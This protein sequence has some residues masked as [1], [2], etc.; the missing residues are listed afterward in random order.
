MLCPEAVCI[1]GVQS[2]RL[3]F[4]HANP[5]RLSLGLACSTQ[6]FSQTRPKLEKVFS[7]AFS[8]LLTLA[9]G[10]RRS[11]P[12]TLRGGEL[13]TSSKVESAELYVG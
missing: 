5:Y 2:E 10:Y 4:V 8:P 1:A 13:F 3:V 12:M 6:T 11:K 7:P 9:P